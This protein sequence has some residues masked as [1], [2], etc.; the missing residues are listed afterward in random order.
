MCS[1]ELGTFDF[2]QASMVTPGSPQTPWPPKN[3]FARSK[4]PA[5][6][7]PTA[8]G[9]SPRCLQLYL[10][11][12]GQASLCLPSRLLNKMTSFSSHHSSARSTM[13]PRAASW[14]F[15]F[16]GSS[17]TLW[18]TSHWGGLSSPCPSTGCSRDHWALAVMWGV[19]QCLGYRKSLQSPVH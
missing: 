18:L 14:H 15:L 2:G 13:R 7:W 12:E 19:R 4:Y 6:T 17:Q 1:W 11:Q 5:S 8:W 16:N 10:L 3:L 9:P